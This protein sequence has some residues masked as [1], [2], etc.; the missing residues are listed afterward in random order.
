[1]AITAAMAV[2]Y[3]EWLKFAAPLYAALLALGAAAIVAAIAL[4]V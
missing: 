1:M 4:G 2:G 3:D